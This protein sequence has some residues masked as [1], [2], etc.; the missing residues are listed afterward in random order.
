MICR[1]SRKNLTE[2]DMRLFELAQQKNTRF[3]AKCLSYGKRLFATNEDA[4]SL[5]V[6][7]EEI[8]RQK[9]PLR[10]TVKYKKPKA[11]VLQDY[12]DLRSANR[13][14]AKRVLKRMDIGLFDFTDLAVL[15]TKFESFLAELFD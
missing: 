15:P 5:I 8:A 2:L 14:P 13:Y 12:V 3:Y 9:V 4:A 1:G 11:A 6:Y 10:K 7:F